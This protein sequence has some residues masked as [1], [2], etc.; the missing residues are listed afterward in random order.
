LLADGH[1]YCPHRIVEDLKL[2]IG[3]QLEVVVEKETDQPSKRLTRNFI[4]LRNSIP[5]L[6][7][8]TETELQETKKLWNS[9]IDKIA[10]EL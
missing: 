2:Q 8:I 5:E 7:S 1:L 6:G 4:S 10:D 9:K 3:S